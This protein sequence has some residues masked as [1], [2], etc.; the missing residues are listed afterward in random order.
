[1]AVTS[2]VLPDAHAPARPS[3]AA[4]ATTRDWG[5]IL[6]AVTGVAVLGL[7]TLHMIANHFMVPEGLRDYSQVVAWLSNP[8]VVALEV[9]FLVTVTWHALLG[10]RAV[11]YDLGPSRRAARWITRGLALIGVLMV[12][13]GLWLTG[14]IT[15]QA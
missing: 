6:Q 5:W 1:M 2:P 14:V 3:A 11:L 9:V 8:L 15:G 4:P 12:G 13:Y 10:V 7:V